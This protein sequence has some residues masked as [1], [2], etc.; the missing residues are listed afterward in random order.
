MV[1][2]DQAEKVTYIKITLRRPA[3]S[4]VVID[5]IMSSRRKMGADKDIYRASGKIWIAKK[6]VFPNNYK[7]S[8]Y[9]NY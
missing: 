1:V 9:G 2:G 6:L 3:L 5:G 4:I 7:L 8:D